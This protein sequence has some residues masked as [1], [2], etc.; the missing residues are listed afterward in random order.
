[1][2]EYDRPH[3]GPGSAS[4]FRN[5]DENA[6]RQRI[7]SAWDRGTKV[8]WDGNTADSMKSSIKIFRTDGP[9][10]RDARFEAISNGEDVTNE[11]ITGPAGAHAAA[12]E[13]RTAERE[14]PLRNYR[15]VMVVHGRNL[16]ARDAMFMFLRALGLDP[17]EWEAAVAETGTASP[18]NLDAVRAAMDVGQAVIVLLTAEDQAGLLPELAGPDGDD[19]VALKGQP[20][21]NVVLEAGLAFG[22][23]PTRTI[24][25]EL[26]PIR[27]ASDFDGLNSVRLTNATGTRNALRSRLISAGCSV[28][29]TASDWMRPEAAGDFDAAVIAWKSQTIR[30][31][32][33]HEGR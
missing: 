22:L 2:F 28:S 10:P 11:F 13:G 31:E 6:L 12:S 25:A 3:S 7:V 9:V 26:G 29:E 14:S 8:T 16:R 18:H 30:D 4:F 21:Q 32:S 17:I 19:D 33:D 20:R 5:V 24:L 15:R 1:M 27:R 23:A